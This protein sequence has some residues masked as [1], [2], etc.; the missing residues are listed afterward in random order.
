L[1]KKICMITD[2][3]GITTGFA[4]AS[5]PIAYGLHNAGYEVHVLGRMASDPAMPPG[6]NLYNA[7]YD[8]TI[9]GKLGIDPD[10]GNRF[11]FA[12][13]PAHPYD[14]LGLR[15][16]NI[17]IQRVKP[18]VVWT[19]TSPG[20]LAVVLSNEETGLLKLQREMGFKIVNY[21]PVENLPLT[22]SFMEVFRQ[23]K[24]HNG[25]NVFWTK[26]SHEAV[27][28]LSDGYIY[29]GMDH[30]DFRKYPLED[31]KFLRQLCGLDDKFLIGTVG[32]NKRTKGLAEMVQVAVELKESGDAENVVFYQHTNPDSPAM[33]GLNL[34]ELAKSYDVLDMFI[35]PPDKNTVNRGNYWAG[36]RHDGTA[37][38]EI[39]KR[40]ITHSKTKEDKLWIFGNTSYIDRMN[41]L[42][43]YLD[44]SQ[45]E[46]F[47]MPVAESLACGTPVLG[48]RDDWVRDELFGE[49]CMGIKPLP[50]RI[51]DYWQ[52]GARLV[53]V[54]PAEV[55]FQIANLRKMPERL[56]EFS[57]LGQQRTSQFKWKDTVEKM[58][59]LI[60]RIANE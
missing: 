56:A 15:I 11:P 59:D 29:F 33:N 32:V 47:G 25:Y 38:N 36:T 30:S 60:G 24:A 23:I 21:G 55:A 12:I 5:R 39:K 53:K 41:M 58:T 22:E 40:G 7:G 10:E 9:L 31:K 45:V 17:M 8:P 37:L 52:T 35:W 50:K 26:C 42:D 6:Y 44:L 43:L 27:G 2:H 34:R 49:A 46:G 16:T 1:K 13:W 20:N 51:W 28:D 54:D 57:E 3:P 14:E 4:N 48:V 18:D 19:M